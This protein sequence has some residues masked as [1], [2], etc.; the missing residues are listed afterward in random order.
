MPTCAG[1]PPPEREEFDQA[2][3]KGWLSLAGPLCQ[4]AYRALPPGGT[5]PTYPLSLD[6]GKEL[7]VKLDS[8]MISDIPGFAW[9]TVEAL[10]QAGIRYLSV[11]H[12]RGYTQF[13]QHGVLVGVPIGRERVLVWTP[14]GGYDLCALIQKLDAPFLS[15][16]SG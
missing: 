8:A 15:L 10:A 1:C 14:Y 7:G 16:V 6:G 3:K 11:G 12:N 4:C 13:R 9:G 2:V 5:A